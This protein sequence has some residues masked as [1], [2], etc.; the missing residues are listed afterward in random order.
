MS[1]VG[2]IYFNVIDALGGSREKKSVSVQ[3]KNIM[4]EYDFRTVAY[5]GASFPNMMEDE[6]YLAVTYSN[7]WV[8]HYKR[9]KYEYIDPVLAMGFSSL[10]PIE[11]R[12]L[13]ITSAR[14]RKFFGEAGEHGLGRQ[15]LTIP[16]RGHMGERALFTVTSDATDA[17]W[18]SR[19]RWLMR[20]FQSIAH[21]FHQMILRVEAFEAPEVDLAPREIECLRWAAHG[22]TAAEIGI[23]LSISERTAEHYINMAKHKLDATNITQAVTKARNL[24][25]YYRSHKTR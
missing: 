21:H 4:E 13:P 23:I 25:I 10:L 7:D 15:G 3:L 14:H 19:C 17:E 1:H 6:P 11:W 18:D 20:D 9:E 8:D 16:V 12:N 22:K 2:D 24:S 5:F